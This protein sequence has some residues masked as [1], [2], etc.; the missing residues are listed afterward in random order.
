VLGVLPG[1][2][3]MIQATETIKWITGI[4]DSLAGRLIQYDALG[5]RFGEF[6]IRKDP[7]CPVCGANATLRELIDYELFCGVQVQEGPP[8][9]EKPPAEILA[10]GRM[11][12]HF[13]FLDVRERAEVEALAIEGTHHIPLG[14]LEA[15]LDELASWKER[16]IVVHCA[17]GGRS[18]QACRVLRERGF[19]EVIN[20]SGGIEAWMR[21][22]RPD[23]KK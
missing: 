12:E 20:L 1:L 8:I 9:S 19:I 16:L 11:G 15:R 18:L 13:L 21:E 6:R 2:I 7:A 14:E 3:A 17:K 22:I 23:S 5:M 4:G 10:L